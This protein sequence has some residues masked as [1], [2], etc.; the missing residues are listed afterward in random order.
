[1]WLCSLFELGI[2]LSWD[3]EPKTS[4]KPALRDSPVAKV[5]G[6][7]DF[8]QMAVAQ[9]RIQVYHSLRLLLS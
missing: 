1:M 4:R 3:T 6:T 2:A 8:L 7:D 9:R 5:L